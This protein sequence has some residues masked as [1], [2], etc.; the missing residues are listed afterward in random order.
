M[1]VLTTSGGSRV[2]AIPLRIETRMP[3]LRGPLVAALVVAM[4]TTVSALIPSTPPA[5][6]TQ[7]EDTVAASAASAATAAGVAASQSQLVQP[8]EVPDGLTTTEWTDIQRQIAAAEAV[9]AVPATVSRSAATVATSP[10]AGG[11]AAPQIVSGSTVA[12]FQPT[13]AFVTA[14]DS[15]TSV[16]FHTSIVGDVVVGS[17]TPAMVNGQAYY[18]HTP[19]I[20]ETYRDTAEGLQQLFTIAEPVTT[21]PTTVIEVEV[22]AGTPSLVDPQSVV[23]E[24]V[25]GARFIYRDV[26]AWDATGALLAAVMDVVDGAITLNVETANAVYPITIDPI[27]SHDQKLILAPDAT[28]ASYGWAVAVDGDRMAV[29]AIGDDTGATNAGAVRMYARAGI[30]SP[31]TSD[32]VIVNPSPSAGDAFGDSVAVF[33]DRVAIGESDRF[34]DQAEAGRM[35]VFERTGAATW[36]PF[37][38]ALAIESGLGVYDA[39]GAS[40]AWQDSTTLVVGAPATA[41]GAGAVYQV[42]FGGSVWNSPSPLSSVVAPAAG[43]QLGYSVDVSQETSGSYVIVAGAP[44]F[45]NPLPVYT[46]SGALHIFRDLDTGSGAVGLQVV[47][48]GSGWD[49]G[50]RMGTAVA[51]DRG[52]LAVAGISSGANGSDLQAYLFEPSGSNFQITA[53]FTDALG[54]NVTAGANNYIDVVGR[55]LFLGR[56]GGGGQVVSFRATEDLAPL[57]PV[58]YFGSV[59]DF[60]PLVR[61]AGDAIGFSVSV[62]GSTL[63]AGAPGDDDSVVPPSPTGDSGAVY[64]TAAMPLTHVFTGAGGDDL[65]SNPDNW[66]TG[67]VPGASPGIDTVIIPA[68][69]TLSEVDGYYSIDRLRVGANAV[70]SVTN[71]STLRF[72]GDQSYVAATGDLQNSGDIVL[73]GDGLLAVDGS[74]T[75]RADG[76]LTFEA[77]TFPPDASLGFDGTG[78]IDN[79]GIIRNELSSPGINIGETVVVNS[80]VDARIEVNPTYNPGSGWFMGPQYLESGTISVAANAYIEFLD[81]LLTDADTNIEIEIAGPSGDPVNFGYISMPGAGLSSPVNFNGATLSASSGY[82]PVPGDRYDV[83]VCTSDCETYDIFASGFVE[84][85]APLAVNYSNNEVSLS[86]PGYLIVDDPSDAVFPGGCTLREAVD[87]ANSSSN[88]GDCGPAAT[89]ANTILFDGSIDTVPLEFSPLLVTSDIT[90]DAT[91]QDVTISRDGIG[92]DGIIRIEPTG[93]LDLL[94]LTIAD[95]GSQGCFVTETCGA[96]LNEGILNVAWVTFSGNN[97][98]GGNGAAIANG[99]GGQLNVSYS[100]FVGNSAGQNGGA[101]WNDGNADIVNSTFYNNVAGDGGAVY[102][103]ATSSAF[104]ITNSTFSDNGAEL[105]ILRNANTGAGSMVLRNTII[106]RPPNPFIDDCDGTITADGFNIDTDGTCGSATTSSSLNLQ[107]LADNGG[108]TQTVAL[109]AGSAAFDAADQAVCAAPP[110]FGVDQRGEVRPQGAGCDSGAYESNGTPAPPAITI[111]TVA[112]DNDVNGNCTLREAILAANSNAAVDACSAGTGPDTIAFGLPGVGPFT[113]SPTSP[114]PPITE[115]LTIDGYSQPGASANTLARRVRRRDPDRARRIVGRC[116]RRSRLHRRRQQR[117]GRARSRHQRVQRLRHTRRPRDP[118]PWQLHR[119]ERHR[120]GSRVQRNRDH[121]ELAGEP[122][123]HDRRNRAGRSQRDLRQL[124]PRYLRDRRR[125]RRGRHDHPRQLHRYRRR[126]APLRCPTLGEG[127]WLGN[128]VSLVSGTVI[129][130][131]TAAGRNVDRRQRGGGHRP[132]DELTEHGDPRQLH[133][134]RGRRRDTARQCAP[135]WRGAFGFCFGGVVIRNSTSNNTVGGNLPGDGN[136]IA[137]NPTGIIAFSGVNNRFV[138]NS[139][140]DNLGRGLEVNGAIPNDPGD[141]DGGANNGQNHPLI[142]PIIDT[143]GNLQV[144]YSIDSATGSSAYPIQIDVYEADSAVSGE[145]KT[146][147]GRSTIAGPGS[148]SVDLGDATTLGVLPGDPMVATA[149][150]ANGNTSNF[151]P[152]AAATLGPCTTIWTNG[153]GDGLWETSGNWTSGVPTATDVV[154]M[155]DLAGASVNIAGTHTIDSFD[156][157]QEVLSILGSGSLTVSNASTIDG[158][159]FITGTLQGDGEI[160]LTADS[161]LNGGTILGS[162][163]VAGGSIM[164]APSGS[165]D[166]SAGGTFTIDGTMQISGD[167]LIADGA[168]IVN[169]FRMAFGS[170]VT[171]AVQI[172]NPFTSTITNNGEIFKSGTGTL[173]LPAGVNLDMASGSSFYSDENAGPVNSFMGGT[174]TGSPSPVT[175]RSES[176]ASINIAGSQTMS[177]QINGLHTSASPGKV[178]FSGTKTTDAGA[179]LNFPEDTVSGIPANGMLEFG[180][181]NLTGTGVWTLDDFSYVSGPTNMIADVTNNGVLSFAG[182]STVQ[183]TLTS[184]GAIGL[185]GSTAYNVGGTGTID[186]SSGALWTANTSIAGP[187]LAVAAL[188]TDS[189]TV[190]DLGVGTTTVNPD[191]TSNGSLSVGSGSLLF[192]NGAVVL[193]PSSTTSFDI[194]GPSSGGGGNF[195]QWNAGSGSLDIGGELT[196]SGVYSPTPV[197]SYAVI[198]GCDCP[199]DTFD[200]L[201]VPSFSADIGLNNIVLSASPCDT[202]WTNGSGDDLWTTAGNWTAGVPGPTDVVCMEVPG[203]AS[204]QINGAGGFKEILRFETAEEPIEIN[205]QLK[206]NEASTINGNLQVVGRL[207]PVQELT[208]GGGATISGFLTGSVRVPLGQTLFFDDLGGTALVSVEAG[209]TITNDGIVQVSKATTLLSGSS[210]VNNDHLVIESDILTIDAG[211]T[212]S[213]NSLLELFADAGLAATVGSGSI[214]NNGVI[215]KTGT[216]AGA[217]ETTTLD[218]TDTSSFEVTAGNLDVTSG[219]AWGSPGGTIS[220]LVDSP[221]VLNVQ[222]SQSFVGTVNGADAGS[223]T[224]GAVVFA[225]TKTA[226]GAT[227]LD[228]AGTMLN[229]GTTELAGATWT[230]DGYASVAGATLTSDVVTTSAGSLS[231][232]GDVT[233]DGTLTNNGF[234]TTAV[235]PTSITGT[236]TF[237]NAGTLANQVTGGALTVDVGTWQSDAVSI[238]NATFE[239]TI[240]FEDTFTELGDVI[241]RPGAL[242]VYNGDVDGGGGATFLTEIS[243]AS[244]DPTAFG[245]YTFAGAVPTLDPT[246]VLIASFNAYTPIASDS[247]TAVTCASGSCPAFTVANVSPLVQSVVAGDIVLALPAVPDPGLLASVD[248]DGDLLVVGAS[249]ANGSDGSAYIY[250]HNGT[251]WILE[252]T[253]AGPV[254]DAGNFGADVAVDNGTVFIGAPA[255][256]TISG[257]ASG[258]V[259]VYRFSGTWLEIAAVDQ[260]PGD[261]NAGDQF[262]AAID[263]TDSVLWVGAPGDDEG[264]IDAGAVYRFNGGP[265]LISWNAPTTKATA[266]D[267]TAAAGLGSS[268]AVRGKNMVV[269]APGETG[270]GQAYVFVQSG[271]GW[272]QRAILQSPNRSAGDAYGAAVAVIGHSLVVTDPAEDLTG[273]DQ[274][275]VYIYDGDLAGWA[276]RDTIE[277]AQVDNGAFGT[278][279]DAIGDLV[280]VGADGEAAG[281]GAVHIFERANITWSSISVETGSAAGVDNGYGVAVAVSADHLVGASATDPSAPGAFASST[282]AHPLPADRLAPSTLDDFDQFGFSVALSGDTA[283]VGAPSAISGIPQGRGTAYVFRNVGGA[284]QLEQELVDPDP[285]VDSGYGYAVAIDTDTIAVGSWGSGIWIWT[286]SGSTWTA[287][288]DITSPATLDSFGAALDLDGASLIVGAPRDDDAAANAGTA[289]VYTGAG[290]TW[291]LESEL[292]STTAT[293][294]DFY[295][296]SV[297]I[298]GDT[299]VVGIPRAND[300]PSTN[301]GAFQVWTRAGAVWTVG[302]TVVSV[303]NADGDLFAATVAI[304]GGKLIVGAPFGDAPGNTNIGWVYFYEI[305]GGS[306]TF[307]AGFMG[308]GPPFGGSQLGDSVAID[309]SLAV[310]GSIEEAGADANAYTYGFDGTQ[311]F[312]LDVL[313]ASDAYDTDDEY[314]DRLGAAVAISGTDVVVGAD[315]DDTQYGAQTGSAY[316]FVSSPA[317]EPAG[318]IIGEP[319][320]ELTDGEAGDL[321]GYS[322]AIDGDTLVVGAPEQAAL[323][324]TDRNRRQRRHR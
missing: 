63:V 107:P 193:A 132:V 179:T 183:G 277:G 230:L 91:G 229:L 136:V 109:G 77:V 130:D 6:Q 45:D 227:T 314:G 273:T 260:D 318:K 242:I 23:I 36:S 53:T 124:C 253:V 168:N 96:V 151:S 138:G 262:G 111:D 195:G 219:G 298:S 31:W 254:G 106:E 189:S 324:S 137:N 85:S 143:G 297:T 217:M 266:S 264:D 228:L 213:N 301:T 196:R 199:A 81:T 251:D 44:G 68:D 86:L 28:G 92:D 47:Q 296:E 184:P 19:T 34:G 293:A 59:D 272:T 121:G 245:T 129:G 102:N 218:M 66:D 234:V 8:G 105:S 90:I 110:V 250:R 49:A 311:W 150:D 33:G 11:L 139:I 255:N 220:L 50:D 144:G 118:G 313:V 155:D 62:D 15:D 154:C 157:A 192:T 55:N 25:E 232:F 223:G 174:W 54:A 235:T 186:L 305:S 128:S 29:S 40:I 240:A 164:N 269:G 188:T 167:I 3:D 99:P 115:P 312:E 239:S 35:Y 200:T 177:G 247:Y 290:A 206:I 221:N 43:D 171:Q 181:V 322:F 166:G 73:Y 263:A 88:V 69:T 233:V 222:G 159:V 74:L 237:V 147:L 122:G 203:T 231:L 156:T 209:S 212:V 285:V 142:T 306:A 101:I 282:P 152:V 83:I 207:E 39:F 70:L 236:G 249:S 82:T 201:N 191:F 309:G 302:D 303:T 295:G 170:N 278:S 30:G 38:S 172:A 291:T 308:Q 10:S 52:Y 275:A 93:S 64:A 316:G 283:V 256:S 24:T 205:G 270:G 123:R 180:L 37:G 169:N 75:N 287:A 224:E 268:I 248:T 76:L 119:Y 125:R 208:L 158:Q 176:G 140:F 22:G 252:E 198:I 190:I 104:A 113:F 161:L 48:A 108:P 117:L 5:A 182:A 267:A 294:S 57:T 149:T 320:S 274:G 175:V 153:V 299:A 98:G 271:I 160:T 17:T 210:I 46:D 120:H 204:V 178:I 87:K 211:A 51:S 67:I 79:L 244:S 317:P 163:T 18:L 94:E 42:T 225:G 72:A 238:V 288:T 265:S 133:R 321:F 310:A 286:R 289:Y 197:D 26:I 173:T 78:T 80:D 146:F 292:P 2:A 32:G 16:T 61:E 215:S 279:V 103:T 323:G 276:L 315:L 14:A 20:T 135:R 202:E 112:D 187:T 95:G 284:W 127:I 162:V 257:A 148:D 300:G 13:G 185:A 58:V 4:I 84:D 246:T 258:A 100:T 116:R 126:P 281:E 259:F 1:N 114:L 60:V 21:D 216:Q 56:P 27:I 41:S 9:E 134:C 65:W 243:G 226:S 261:A 280:V 304:D 131:G 165:I 97:A 145:G 12:R 241:A 319:G 214:T 194:S 7:A 89:G 307:Q 71:S 141:V